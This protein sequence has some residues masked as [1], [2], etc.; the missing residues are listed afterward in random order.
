MR[1][2]ENLQLKFLDQEN[3]TFYMGKEIAK[4][5]EI[6]TEEIKKN[7]KK[8]N[9]KDDYGIEIKEKKITYKILETLFPY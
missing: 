7:L 6:V 4:N 1:L 3:L 8:L 5:P 9:L 2:E